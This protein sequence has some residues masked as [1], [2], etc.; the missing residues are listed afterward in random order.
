MAQYQNL[1]ATIDAQIKANGNHEITGPVLNAVL[2]NLISVLGDG[3][4]FKGVAVPDDNPGTPDNRVF[5]I[6]GSPGT[7]ANF[8][9]LVVPDD[10]AA[11][12]LTFDTVWAA[13]QLPAATTASVQAVMA[14]LA[15]KVDKEEGKVL[16]TNDFTDTDKALLD[17]LQGGAFPGLFAGFTANLIDTR[18]NGVAQSFAFR[19]SGGDGVD[20]LKRI[21]GKTR[22]WNQMVDNGTTEV[23]TVSGHKYLTRISGAD[24]IVTSTGTSIAI[25][26][27][28]ADNVFDLTLMFGSGNEPST[29]D[30]FRALFPLPYY[31]FNAGTLINNAATALETVGFNQ[32]DEE[33]EVGTLNEV[34]GMP[35][36]SSSYIRAKNYIPALPNTEYYFIGGVACYAY[37]KAYNMLTRFFN[38]GTGGA[39]TT[40]AGT[41]FIRFRSYKQTTTYNH[42]IC[43]NI[44]DPSRNGTYEPYWKRTLPLGLSSFE[45][46]TGSMTET[47]TGLNGVPDGCDIITDGT[48]FQRNI[49]EVEFDGTETWNFAHNCFWVAISPV[50]K[51][52]GRTHRGRGVSSHFGYNTPAVGFPDSG[53]W[54][55]TESNRLYFHRELVPSLASSTSAED[56]KAWLAAQW[57]AGTPL[58]VQYVLAT[59]LE[60]N[61]V[62]PITPYVEVDE[63]G[64]ERRL[65]ED[66]AA[67]PQ[68]PFESDSNYSVSIA[69][70]TRKLAA[71]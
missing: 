48:H 6:A 10:S 22:V 68:A 39:A 13:A 26:D 61:L 44:S 45:A 37:D 64:T 21:K 65:P 24:A 2:K 38:Q 11:Y 49:Q 16:S 25:S 41:A 15:D 57:N 55:V 7:Y 46:T 33:W 32:W 3:Y 67:A 17:S 52:F 35:E 31:S 42:D 54:D 18:S 70:L 27:S 34:S 29:V 71:L 4:R 63:D 36:S 5:Y 23:A 28:S 40:P 58:K 14:A 9:G 12:I 51:L 43:V 1:Q 60:Y 66:T 20:Y 69:N 19:K 50:A 8:G 47:F 62:D 59:P 30:E 53:T 56:W